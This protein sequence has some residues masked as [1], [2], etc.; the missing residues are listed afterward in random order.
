MGVHIPAPPPLPTLAPPPLPPAI[1]QALKSA[2]WGYGILLPP[3]P[4]GPSPA[5]ADTGAELTSFS[6]A[7]HRARCLR[8]PDKML[9]LVGQGRPFN[10]HRPTPT[11]SWSGP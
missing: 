6:Q 2:E 8:L 3:L 1:C 5:A 9:I 10:V 11:E 4:A 7:S